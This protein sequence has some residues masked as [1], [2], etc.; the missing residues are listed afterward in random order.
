M[1]TIKQNKM[2]NKILGIFINPFTLIL[3]I[4][5]GVLTGIRKTYRDNVEFFKRLEQ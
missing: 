4:I 3:N 1:N 2:T 5:I